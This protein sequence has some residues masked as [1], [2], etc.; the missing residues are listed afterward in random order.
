M[1]IDILVAEIGSTTTK[2]S[3]FD[4]IN[5]QKP[6]FLGQGSAPTTVLNGDVTTGLKKAIEDL[7]YR[8]KTEELEAKESFACSSAA[9]GLKMSVHGLVYEMTA[10]AAKEAALGA[11][12]NLH[13]LTAGLLTPENLTAIQDLNL[14]IIMIAG[15]VD[16]GEKYTSLS[17]AKAI[18]RLRLNIP[19]IYA[20][21][22]ENQEAV[23]MAFLE[24][25]QEKYLYITDNVYPKIDVLA[26]ESAR[27]VIQ[28]VFENH[29]TKAPGMEKVR[30][31]ITKTIIPTPGAVLKT[32]ILMQKAI[33]D[34]VV[35]DVGGATT[36]IHSVTEGSKEV[37]RQ[38]MSPEPFAK[39]TVEG[40]LGV[41]IN[42][43][44]L[45]ATTT[46][47]ILAKELRI[48]ETELF[49][50]LDKYKALPNLKQIPVVQY[51]TKIALCMALER[52]VGR[53]ASIYGSN[54]KSSIPEG[55]DLTNVAYIIGTGGALSRLPSGKKILGE[56]LIWR[57]PR[58]LLPPPSAK[59]LIDRHYIMAAVGAFCDKYPEASV[60][61][62]KDSYGI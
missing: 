32:A 47:Q 26:V 60:K 34:L 62:M 8:L 54:G 12:A 30:E 14:N 1:I 7:K 33:G 24:N 40:D 4:K 36:D 20:G 45:L 49:T 53:Y 52:H 2:V 41:Y 21:N 51:L 42:R 23:K 37:Q 15:G 29:I 44:R 9:G 6:L 55:K 27:I 58:L 11:G 25:G 43:D 22:I 38:A 39:R 31:M 28:N 10:K 61:L 50:I 16:Y 48:S 57:D 19:V 59:I 46:P 5:D 17:N 56:I 35:A 18:A 13:L 3:A